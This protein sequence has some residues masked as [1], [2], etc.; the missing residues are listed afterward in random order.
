MQKTTNDLID[1]YLKIQSKL[2]IH[3]HRF[4]INDLKMIKFLLS[5][6]LTPRD[7][8]NISNYQSIIS[9]WR[10]YF[11]YSNLDANG[12]PTLISWVQAQFKVDR[13]FAS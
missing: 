1:E 7:D 3:F 11:L 6:Y 8:K 9:L 12:H 2:T 13:A 4:S 5:K 10:W